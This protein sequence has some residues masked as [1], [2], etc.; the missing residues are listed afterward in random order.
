M[1]CSVGQ[2]KGFYLV[3]TGDG[4]AEAT[5]PPAWVG[6]SLTLPSGVPVDENLN[7][8]HNRLQP[9]TLKGFQSR[10]VGAKFRNELWALN[11]GVR[12]AEGHIQVCLSSLGLRRAAADPRCARSC[13][14]GPTVD[15]LGSNDQPG[16]RVS[17]KV[18]HMPLRTGG[19]GHGPAG[20]GAAASC[21]NT[22]RGCS[23]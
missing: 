6:R 12:K 20:G 10:F 15:L 3:W 7:L 22:T 17:V 8:K 14:H 19:G 2:V 23:G 18:W 21:I 16:V 1:S 5:A 11:G 4:V 9:N 13:C